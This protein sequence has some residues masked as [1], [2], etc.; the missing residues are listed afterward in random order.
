MSK[1]L[2]EQ[3]EPALIHRMMRMGADVSPFADG[4]EFAGFRFSHGGSPG[5]W[6]TNLRYALTSLT[7]A[8]RRCSETDD[9]EETREII[10]SI[11]NAMRRSDDAAFK[12]I[13]RYAIHKWPVPDAF[14]LPE[15]EARE[16]NLDAIVTKA[17]DAYRDGGVR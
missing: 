6:R 15:L 8:E 14:Q 17:A 16:G 10:Y 1:S 7:A 9:I 4:D 11:W 3:F 5:E 12:R 2:I 13:V